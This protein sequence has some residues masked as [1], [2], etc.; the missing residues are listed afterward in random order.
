MSDVAQTSGAGAGCV[1]EAGYRHDGDGGGMPAIAE[2]GR[3]RRRAL[4]SCGDAEWLAGELVDSGLPDTAAE[5]RASPPTRSPW[6]TAGGCTTPRLVDAAAS[7]GQVREKREE[8]EWCL[9]QLIQ[10]LKRLQQLRGKGVADAVRAKLAEHLD[11]EILSAK[12]VARAAAEQAVI[13]SCNGRWVHV[14]SLRSTDAVVEDGPPVRRPVELSP[15]RCLV[16]GAAGNRS[17][18]QPLPALSSP[19]DVPVRVRPRFLFL[20]HSFPPGS[21]A[22]HS[23]SP[24]PTPAGVGPTTLTGGGLTRRFPCCPRVFSAARPGGPTTAPPRGGS[25]GR[26]TH[27]RCRNRGDWYLPA[28]CVAPVRRRTTP[29]H[30]PQPGR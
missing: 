16:F 27:R 26:R 14:E 20:T 25:R 17:H 29:G 15:P 4:R 24:P 19:S 28:H 5:Y 6:H 12:R 3:R 18:W 23:R 21:F 7:E 11:R 13:V 30:W 22:R 10:A 2:A 9:A 8:C 1:G